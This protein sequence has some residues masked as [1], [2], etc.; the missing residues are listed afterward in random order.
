MLEISHSTGVGSSNDLTG[1]RRQQ[2]FLQLLVLG[3]L[4]LTVA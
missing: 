2:E 4:V 1:G 3:K